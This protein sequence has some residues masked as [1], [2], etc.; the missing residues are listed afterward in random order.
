MYSA[1]KFTLIDF[2]NEIGD[3]FFKIFDFF[4]HFLKVIKSNETNEPY[5]QSTSLLFI[6]HK[7]LIDSY[8]QYLNAKISA[9]FLMWLFVRTIKPYLTILNAYV[10]QG[11]SEVTKYSQYELGFKRN[12][13]ITINN[14]DYWTKGYELKT[15]NQSINET[16]FIGI[17]LT[18]AYKISKHMEIVR[19]LD[20]YEFN[21]NIYESFM[22]SILICCPYL[23]NNDQVNT[24]LA[25]QH[26]IQIVQGNQSLLD[27][28]FKQLKDFSN[29][30]TISE[31]SKTMNNEIVSIEALMDSYF[32]L[33]ESS[34]IHADKIIDLN[35]EKKIEDILSNCLLKTVDWSSSILIDKLFNKY[36][37]CKFFDFL[38]SYYM[39]K[40][41]E[42]M[43][44]FSKRLFTAIKSKEAYQEDALLNSL[45]YKSSHSVFTTTDQIIKSMFS[46][47]LVTFHCE[48]KSSP[49]DSIRQIRSIELKVKLV[50]PLNI[51]VQARNFE[52]YNKIFIFL[53]QIK[54]AKFELD[55][56]DLNDMDIRK[57]YAK[58]IT[59]NLMNTNIQAK[60]DE[61]SV[62]KMFSIRFK[63]MNFVNSAHDLI[64]NQVLIL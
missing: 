54:Q 4:D 8:T 6:I 35:M 57:Y 15:S 31:L 29:V 53:M 26:R 7:Y 41:N 46:S 23:K 32:S 3:P 5:V 21:L 45:F 13:E 42:I 1:V 25:I 16:K 33:N 28:N 17:V 43:F 44:L 63:L 58:T 27:I 18:S 59:H 39:F 2:L 60:I 12:V 38:Q 62:K 47:N 9:K 36:Q 37:M 20:D 14:P 50:W 48:A 11:D 52:V 22:K 64:C 55:S 10:Q 61:L 30:A 24:D 49:E 19:L 56:L 34:S 40:S 51:I